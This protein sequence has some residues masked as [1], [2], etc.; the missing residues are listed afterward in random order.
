MPLQLYK[1]LLQ[2]ND[3]CYSQGKKIYLLYSTQL[4][5]H[6]IIVFLLF[7][8]IIICISLLLFFFPGGKPYSYIKQA[9]RMLCYV[10]KMDIRKTSVNTTYSPSIQA[11]HKSQPMLYTSLFQYLIEYILL[12][13][14][15]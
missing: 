11:A 6:F 9:C 15:I 5:P 10:R 8:V 13:V 2:Q 14:Y 4:N 3:F 12:A 1:D 7:L